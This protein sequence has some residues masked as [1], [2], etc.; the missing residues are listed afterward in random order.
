MKNRAGSDETD[1][2]ELILIQRNSP[3]EAESQGQNIN[4]DVIK[5][6]GG[7]EE[8]DYQVQDSDFD[9]SQQETLNQISKGP[10]HRMPQ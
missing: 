3:V 2:K 9:G 4:D 8:P 10:G 1:M 7:E 6:E 5:E